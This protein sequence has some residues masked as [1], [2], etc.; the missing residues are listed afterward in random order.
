MGMIKYLGKFKNVNN[1]SGYAS[2]PGKNHRYMQ[3]GIA[4]IKRRDIR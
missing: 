1:I 4:S 2:C 3:N